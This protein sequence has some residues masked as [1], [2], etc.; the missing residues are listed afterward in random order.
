MADPTTV[1]YA[2]DNPALARDYDTTSDFQFEHGKRLA[3][4]LQLRGGERVLDVGA[5]TGRLAL[6]LAGL[7]GPQGEV[8][9]VDPLADRVALA[10][11]R[12]SANLQVAQARAEDLGAYPDDHFD[13]VVLN[14]VFHWIADQPAAL[15]E[16]WRVL[17]PGGRLAVNS[18]DA[19]RPHEFVG[20]L[21]EGLARQGVQDRRGLVPPHVIN[22]ERF[23]E[24]L[25]RAG[26][27]ELRITP[28]TFHDRFQDLEHLL[29][30]NQSSYFGNFLPHLDLN[31][32]LQQ[33]LREALAQRT[34]AQGIQLQRHLV[35]A[36][37]RKPART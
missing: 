28:L 7:V 1:S 26:F 4:E 8:V 10:R 32:P 14:S 11:S 33:P 27:V 35:F 34:D 9:A 5:G 2:Q 19:D 15:A 17:R 37:A 30:W 20:L 36:W 23:G 29:R 6:H 25:D 12:A 31:G 22:E 18:A 24:L 13:A 16:A 3:E 21:A